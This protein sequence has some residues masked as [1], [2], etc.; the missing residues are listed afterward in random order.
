MR[1][2]SR[3]V[4]RLAAATAVAVLASRVAWA[5]A[6]PDRAYVADSDAGEILVVDLADFSVLHRLVVDSQPMEVA[7]AADGSLVCTIAGPVLV[8]IDPASDKVVGAVPLG[9]VQGFG[10]LA[11]SHDGA[12]IYAGDQN[13]NRV[14]VVDRALAISDPSHAVTV[15]IPVF[16]PPVSIILSPDG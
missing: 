14:L 15:S 5:G 9:A 11:V 3:V 7:A 4:R 6:M 10:G 12:K 16:V 1:R 2:V 8:L 13:S